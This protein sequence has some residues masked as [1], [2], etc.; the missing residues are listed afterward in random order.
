MKIVAADG[1]GRTPA[2]LAELALADALLPF[3][4]CGKTIQKSVAGDIKRHFQARYP[5]SSHYSPDKVLEGDADGNSAEVVV[6][7]PGVARAYRDV[8]IRPVRAKKLAIPTAAAEALPPRRQEGLFYAKNAKGTEM[9][10]KT[11]GGALV[12]VYILKDYVHQARDPGIMP[13]DEVLAENALA[14]VVEERGK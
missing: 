5:G 10:A 13:S 1:T 12:A 9:L 8:D 11:E 4:S 14:R 7:V 6:D 3:E 2:R